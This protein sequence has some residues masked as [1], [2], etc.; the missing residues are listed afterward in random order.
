MRKAKATTCYTFQQGDAPL[1]VSIPHAGVLLEKSMLPRM[2]EV[3]KTLADTD[4]FVDQLYDFLQKKNVS[5]ITAS[6]SRYVIDLNRPAD[7]TSLYSGQRETE[8]CPLTSFADHAIYVEGQAPDHAEIEKRIENFWKPYHQKIEQELM[9]L[10][11]RHG[12]ALLWDAHSIKSVVP[13]FFEGRLP[14]LNI[15]TANNNSCDHM[16]GQRL[17]SIAQESNNYTAVLNGRFKGG[18]ITRHYGQPQNNI[19]AVQLE[20]VQH[21]YMQETPQAIFSDAKAAVLRPVLE[22]MIDC[23]L[24]FKPQLM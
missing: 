23:A 4:W 2:T 6:Y 13:R 24:G 15:G 5:I 18:Y 21:N 9:R 17:L 11:A 16:L 19:H 12:Y 10:K 1:L 20:L 8:L 7:G 22:A 3:A 14:D